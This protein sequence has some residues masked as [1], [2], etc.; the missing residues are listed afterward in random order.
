[1]DDAREW[2]VTAR[3]AGAGAVNAVQPGDPWGGPLRGAEPVLGEVTAIAAARPGGVWPRALAL[4]IDTLVVAVISLGT[5]MGRGLGA[6]APR[7]FLVGEAFAVTWGIFA[8][9]AY[10]VLAH[11]T[12]GQ[13]LGKWLL[14]LRVVDR[15]GGPI[16]YGHALGRYAATI[17][18]AVPG[19]LGLLLAAFRP[20]RRGLHDL[21]AG[22]RVVR[23]R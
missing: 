1:M 6:F 15:E 17:I 16:G 5:S 7:F 19:G 22:T 14:G 3:A 21:L 20:D 13:T 9:S 18:A 4:A 2:L 10:F 8:P 11:G 23:V 12:G